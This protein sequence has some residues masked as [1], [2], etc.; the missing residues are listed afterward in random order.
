MSW[1]YQ[2]NLGSKHLTRKLAIFTKILTYTKSSCIM[3][4]AKTSQYSHNTYCLQKESTHF[5]LKTS[6]PFDLEVQHNLGLKNHA[7]KIS[8]I[9]KNFELY[10]VFMYNFLCQT[11]LTFP[12]YI[13]FTYYPN[14]LHS[15]KLLT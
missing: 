3:F 4:Y 9:H 1:E 12:F 8:D 10:Q 11:V 14:Y 2:Y 15:T 13:L 6:K 7:R 5:G